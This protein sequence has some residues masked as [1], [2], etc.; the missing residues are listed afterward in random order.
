M[1]RLA[2]SI[3]SVR[4]LRYFFFSSVRESKGREGKGDREGWSHGG[5]REGEQ[6]RAAGGGTIS[7]PELPKIMVREFFHGFHYGNKPVF[8]T[9][10][11][12]EISHR[13]ASSGGIEDVP[14]A[15][16]ST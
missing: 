4:C 8:S 3:Y 7:S 12:I 5:V 9:S 13:W 11:S 14:S 10:C 1:Q 16:R 6:G 15:S 2:L